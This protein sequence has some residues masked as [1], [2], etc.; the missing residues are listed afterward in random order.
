M[1]ARTNRKVPAL[2]A[3]LGAVLGLFAAA[4]AT[5][6]RRWTV[7]ELV[8]MLGDAEPRR[9]CEAAMLLQSMGKEALP[10]LPALQKAEA[11]PDAEVGLCATYATAHVR[12]AALQDLV[13]RAAQAL[14]LQRESRL[15]TALKA[16][17]PRV[18]VR[19]TRLISISPRGSDEETKALL[20][21]LSDPVAEVRAAA[22]RTLGGPGRG[23]AV[24]TAFIKALEDP[25]G[26]VRSSAAYGLA[27]APA[28][29]AV[30]PLVGALSDASA[31][32]RQAAAW[33][34]GSCAA[35]LEGIRPAEEALLKALRDEN[36]LVR[37][38]AASALRKFGGKSEPVVVALME[39][40]SD[41]DAQVRES[42]AEALGYTG[43]HSAKAVPALVA[44]VK[45]E[46][47]APRHWGPDGGGGGSIRIR[48]MV[49][50]TLAKIG[51]AAVPGL[52]ECL[53]TPIPDVRA[54]AARAL[55]QIGPTAKAAAPAL[56]KA[57]Q[58]ENEE[59]RSSAAQ[60][61]KDITRPQ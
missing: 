5:S 22:A 21:A 60:A 11:D 4:H 26:A 31:E 44:A 54:Q 52:I 23:E 41:A 35:S 45:D 56:E 6:P 20:T 39:A 32:V 1:N 40:L 59:V 16:E 2:L 38:S 30:V 61:L 17:D 18:R 43:P 19:A 8:K 10:A 51:E 27:S 46:K 53:E 28:E 25:D 42:T 12:A 36:P 13:D 55:G 47:N 7:E 24:V 34:I 29:A 33:A 15:L 49:A 57:L 58:D 50:E 14:L 37:R 3:A 48:E 9:R